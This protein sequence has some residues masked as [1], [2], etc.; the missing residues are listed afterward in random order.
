MTCLGTMRDGYCTYIRLHNN[1][2]PQ[3][4]GLVLL[5]PIVTK[6]LFGCAEEKGSKQLNKRASKRECERSA[7][8]NLVPNAGSSIVSLLSLASPR[9]QGEAARAR[10]PFLIQPR[11]LQR[12]AFSLLQKSPLWYFLALPCLAVA[13]APEIGL[14]CRTAKSTSGIC[15]Q[16]FIPRLFIIDPAHVLRPEF[17]VGNFDEYSLSSWLQVEVLLPT[18]SC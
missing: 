16:G 3:Q 6:P 11:P 2:P 5:R 8:H 17:F 9:R 7:I 4:V 14:S 10:R 18:P 15:Q 12:R 13:L 1:F